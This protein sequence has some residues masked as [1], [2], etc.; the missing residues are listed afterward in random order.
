MSDTPRTEAARIEYAN[1]KAQVQPCQPPSSVVLDGWDFARILE[2]QLA[3][4][5]A[6]LKKMR[7]AFETSSTSEEN[8]LRAEVERMQPVVD[9]ARDEILGGSIPGA[10]E[11]AVRDYEAKEKQ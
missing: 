2:R 4:A 3:K 6:D 5:Q 1:W 10:L 11:K 9:A 7:A 8:R